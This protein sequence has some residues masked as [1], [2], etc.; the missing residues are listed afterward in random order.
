MSLSSLD[1]KKV[2]LWKI[3]PLKYQQN[4]GLEK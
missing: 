3:I 4:N 1:L 2:V